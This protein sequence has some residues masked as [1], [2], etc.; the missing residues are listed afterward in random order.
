MLTEA[1]QR[2]LEV[3]QTLD[4]L[5]AGFMLA[6]HDLDIR[7]AG[8]LLGAGTIGPY[9]RGRHR[10]LSAPAGRGGRR[11]RAAAQASRSAEEWTPQITL[12]TP[13]LIPETYVGRP[14]SAPWPLPPRRRSWSTA[15]EIDAFAAELVDRFGPLPPEV[16]NLL[17]TIAIKQL[18][19]RAG[20]QK[21]DAGPKG[22][23]L[24][25]RN[26]RFANPAGLVQFLQ[27]QANTARLRPDQRLVVTRSWD[28]PR[29]RL[30]GAGA[31][32]T[33]LAE[34]AEKPVKVP[35]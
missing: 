17:E 28:V 14:E 11:R 23:V 21:F 35:A 5:G 10:A 30:R 1:A 24:S 34:I 32:L 6:S 3:M 33:Q 4:Q 26:E 8:N 31:L 19:R 15:R 22:A 29:E 27:S 20:V 16:D 7:G 2:R 12:G 18:C 13:V 25:F 9:P